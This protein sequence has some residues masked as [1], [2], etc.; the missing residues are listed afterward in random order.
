[1]QGR[2]LEAALDAHVTTRD[3]QRGVE[4]LWFAALDVAR[5]KPRLV[6]DAA[7]TARAAIGPAAFAAGIRILD[8]CVIPCGVRALAAAPERDAMRS[9]ARKLAA[10]AIGPHAR[11]SGMWRGSI[12]I[13]A[14]SPAVA[15]VWRSYLRRCERAFEGNDRMERTRL[16]SHARGV[17]KIARAAVPLAR[18]IERANDAT[19]GADEHAARLRRYVADHDA[20]ADD[21][22]AFARLCEVVFAQGLGIRVVIAKREALT[23]AFAGFDPLRVSAFEEADVKR[24]RASPIIRNESKIRACIENAGR[25][26]SA[27]GADTYLA[28]VAQTAATDDPVLGWPALAAM[29]VADFERI[30]E[31]GARQT[32]KRWG[33][34]SALAHPGARRVVARLGLVQDEAGDARIQMIIGAVARKLCRDP[35][36]LEGALA[37]FAALGPCRPVA[38]C[39]RCPLSERCPTGARTLSEKQVAVAAR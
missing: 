4:R 7:R 33:F 24:L 21:A 5:L 19:L 20:P 39:D 35:Y 16:P 17:A 23:A 25:W 13:A 6:G 36:S 29:L 34:F 3:I 11:C 18:A 32:L 15:A 8:A 12:R 10:G 27:S 1:M 38:R 31:S 26:R 28:R 9:F 22:A 37:L 2:P 30:G 14:V